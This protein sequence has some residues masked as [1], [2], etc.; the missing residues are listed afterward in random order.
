MKAATQV[1]AAK[2][3]TKRTIVHVICVEEHFLFICGKKWLVSKA[4]LSGRVHSSE[5]QLP[6]L[7]LKEFVFAFFRFF[8]EKKAVG[9]R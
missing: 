3:M 2:K 4:Q 1:V 7:K 5:F 9:D 6:G 8:A